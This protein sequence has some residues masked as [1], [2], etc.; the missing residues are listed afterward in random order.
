M[1]SFSLVEN[2][3]T[4]PRLASEPASRSFEVANGIENILEI[5]ERLLDRQWR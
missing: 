4:S 5:P 3:G 2:R 1:Y